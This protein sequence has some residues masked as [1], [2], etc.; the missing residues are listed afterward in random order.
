MQFPLSDFLTLISQTSSVLEILTILILVAISA[1]LGRTLRR[2]VGDEA[3]LPVSGFRRLAF[4]L[5][6]IALL[7]LLRFFAHRFGWPLHFVAVAVQLL[8]ALAAVRMVVFALRRAFPNS[9]AAP[10]FER[11]LVVLIWA[12]FA[13]DLLGILPDLIEWLD[14]YS[15][16][17]GKVRITF[18]EILQAA[19]SVIS[20]LIVALWIGGIVEGRL[21][22]TP[23]L[24]SNLKVVFSRLLRAVLIVLA[25]LIG[26]SMAG[27]DITTLSVFGG[28]LG[29]GLAFGM[30]KIAANYISG[31]IIL[32]DKSIQIG[33]LIQVGQDRGEVR[34]I[35]T[36]YT[37]LKTGTGMHVIVPNETLVSST[38]QNETYADPRQKASLR[39]QIA[40][41]SDVDKAMAI[42]VELAQGQSRV[43]EDPAPMAFL[44]SLDDSGVTL[45]LGFW[46]ADP[47]NGSLD[48]RSNINRAILK[49]FAEEN[50]EIPYPQREV[51]VVNDASG[52]AAA[53]R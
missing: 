52:F 33:N 23:A 20:T 8:V 49:R 36:R 44:I 48:I 35:T 18:W 28:A 15:M 24:D 31:F 17:V 38:V 25:I 22:E 2:R 21:M 41:N 43:I 51:R 3:W 30:Q 27:L 37:V 5:V 4:P 46:I 50:I 47:Q 6:G 42:L 19:V 14:G 26:M 13:L 34:Q 39:V 16:H 53:V 12:G 11:A 45:E 40:Y 1:F 32:L 10:G 9:I 7:S 29:V